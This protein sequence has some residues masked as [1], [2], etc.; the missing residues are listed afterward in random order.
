MKT[1]NIAINGAIGSAV[2]KNYRYHDILF[3]GT[4]NNGKGAITLSSADPNFRV[5]LTGSADFGGKTIAAKADIQLDSIDLQAL[6]LYT[7]ELRARGTIHADF[8]SLDTDYPKG[9]FTWTKPIINADGKRYYLDSMYIVSAPDETKGQDITAYFDAFSAHITGKT[10]LTKIGSI[11]EQRINKRYTPPVPDSAAVILFNCS[12]NTAIKSPPKYTTIIPGQY[13]LKITAS[14]TD[15]PMLHS[16]I[17]DLTEFDSIYIDGSIDERSLTLNVDVPRLVY[18]SNTIQKAA[19]KVS[20]TD[21]AFTYK[22]TVD[23][24]A[25][26]GISLW[27]ADVHGNVEQNLI[28]ANISIA[29]SLKKERFALAA[30]MQ[31]DGDQQ[32][33]T[34]KQGLKLNYNIWDVTPDNKIVLTNNGFY[35]QNFGIS[36]SGQFIKANSLTASADAMLKVDITNFLLSNITSI[37]NAGDTILANGILGAVVTVQKTKGG[38]Q[39]TGDLEI[40]N[41]SVLGDTMGNLK[42]LVNNKNENTLNAQMAL[43]GK[44]NDILIDGAYYL[45]PK[46]GNDF[47]L[48]LAMKALSLQ[49]FESFARGQI[50]KSSGFVRGSLHLTGIPT[51]PIINGDL[52]TDNLRTTVTA[53]NSNFKFPAENIKFSDNLITLNNFTILD[54]P[55]NKATLTGTINTKNLTEPAFDLNVV[56]K[57]WRAIHSTIS[58]NKE[59]YGDLV[60]TANLDIQGTP[61]SL[62][63]DGSLNILKGTDLTIVTPEK[64]PEIESAVGIVKFVN[65]RDNGRKNLLIPKKKE[66]AQHKLAKGS[67]INVNIVVDKSAKFSLVIDQASG[68]FISVRGDATLNASVARNGTMGLT[69]NYA[70]HDGAYQLNYNFIKRKFLIKEGSNIIFAGDPI[71]GTNMDVTAVYEAN[72]P[73]YDLVQRQVTDQAALNYYK[74]RIPFD[75]ELHLKGPILKPGI[76]FDLNLPEGKVY[77]LAPDQIELIQGKLSQVRTDTSE[78]NKQVFAVMIL[79]RFVSDDPFSSKASSSAGFT[80][81]QSVSTFIGEQLNKAANNFVKGV[82]FSVDMA[83]TEDYTSG[84]LRQRTDLNLAASKQL[85]NDRLKLTIGNNF[86]LEGPQTANQQN[87]YVPTN[88]AADYLLSADGKYTVR[89]YRKA[90]D[91][92]VL[93]GFVTET[94]VNFIVSLDYNNFKSV[95]KKKKKITDS[96]TTQKSN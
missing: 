56:A 52:Q 7:T 23:K 80:A 29:D 60:V 10:P 62:Q 64:T 2:A 13:N 77:P 59:F 1:M 18:G 44:G 92:G 58:D 31:N 4:V 95:L 36:N 38:Q 45:K 19:L 88:L 90:Y 28:T 83:T 81:L 9:I 34:L 66:I 43:T 30:N 84:D 82:D 54:S 94:G 57:N 32:V 3:C 8:P 25:S 72:V 79:N 93:E 22:V 42:V 74:Q 40:L 76:N 89:G 69:G 50:K 48:Q 85:F 35:I 41:L 86:E 24:I 5:H 63:V 26:S 71:N 46:N 49:S 11:I 96:A 61:L 37:A 70:L 17:P 21:D 75:V 68:D 87:S 55:D 39:I 65:S 78:L 14:L 16:I 53:I 12:T 27:Y 51:A 20:G 67:D 6:K 15:K 91:E 47:D 33:I 73:P